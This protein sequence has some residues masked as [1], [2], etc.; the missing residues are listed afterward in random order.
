[1][2]TMDDGWTGSWRLRV[3]S[4]WPLKAVDGHIPNL[5]AVPWRHSPA[6]AQ[7]AVGPA[8]GQPLTLPRTHLTFSPVVV[9]LVALSK[10]HLA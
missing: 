7:F 1:M 9:W 5:F 6:G 8:N 10:L 2:S 4:S 3:A